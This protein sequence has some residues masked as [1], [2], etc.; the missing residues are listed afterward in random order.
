LHSRL[1]VTA[2][3]QAWAPA[4]IALAT[5]GV[6]GATRILVELFADLS[7]GAGKTV[8]LFW[9]QVAWLVALT[10]A[11]YFGIRWW[12]IAGAGVAHAVV[13]SLVVIPLYVRAL[14]SVLHITS[15][16]LLKGS[17]PS[18]LGAAL[19]GAAAWLGT[20]WMDQPWA[21]LG[22]GLLLGAAVYAMVSFRQGR[23]LVAEVRI[24]LKPQQAALQQ[25]AGEGAL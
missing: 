24:L 20:H 19:A 18:L 4:G 1:I 12:G 14:T 8:W 25:A 15:W 16:N 23:R 10:P 13:A 7:V 17:V 21:A 11:L 3:G 2:Y 22:A 5:L 6:F 9:V